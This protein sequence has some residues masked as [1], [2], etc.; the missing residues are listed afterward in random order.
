MLQTQIDSSVQEKRLSILRQQAVEAN[1]K[2]QKMLR[3]QQDYQE[4]QRQYQFQAKMVNEFLGKLQE[5]RVQKAQD[6]FTWKVIEPP[7]LPNSPIARSRLR[8]LI[9]GGIAGIL[10]GVGVAFVL[11]K[12]NFRLKDIKSI[13]EVTQ[14]EILGVIPQYQT[15]MS[16][17]LGSDSFTEAI[18]SLALTLSFQNPQITGK[19]IAVTSA[20]TEEGKTTITYNLGL[21]L[22]E[23]GKKY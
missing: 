12:F 18:R 11:E 10:A 6:T 22:T 1:L 2:L 3:L 13:Q 15:A 4:L 20:T 17:G 5:L 21:A 16:L 19:I 23:I 8:G 9:L 7:N 14:L